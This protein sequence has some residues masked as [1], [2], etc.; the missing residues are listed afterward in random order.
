MGRPRRRRASVW[1]GVYVALFGV[2]ED[3]DGEDDEAT[4]GRDSA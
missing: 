3:E 2:P 1:A 4:D